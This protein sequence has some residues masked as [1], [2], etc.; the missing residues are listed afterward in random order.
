MLGR[1][2]VYPSTECGIISQ[3]QHKTPVADRPLAYLFTGLAD[4]MVDQPKSRIIRPVNVAIL[5]S[6]SAGVDAARSATQTQGQIAMLPPYRQHMFEAALQIVPSRRS[7]AIP[8]TTILAHHL[9][10]AR[11]DKAQ[12]APAQRGTPP[13]QW[14][15]RTFRGAHKFAPRRGIINRSDFQRVVPYRRHA[16]GFTVT[17]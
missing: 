16:A 10:L 6:A 11:V 14:P 5:N 15:T 8:A 4:A 3:I 13:R 7:L 1:V 12:N 2:D 17:A 9:P